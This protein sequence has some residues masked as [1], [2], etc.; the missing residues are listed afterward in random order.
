MVLGSENFIEDEWCQDC[1]SESLPGDLP[2]LQ[3]LAWICHTVGE[4]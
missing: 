2:P 1:H 3:R 4:T